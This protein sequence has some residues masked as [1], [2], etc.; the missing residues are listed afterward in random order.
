MARWQSC[1]ILD[2]GIEAHRLWQFDA[3]GG[4]FALKREHA[5]AAGQPLPPSLAAKSWR[6]LF[7][8]RLNIAWLPPENVFL[9]V[10]EL[11]SSNFEETLAMVELQLE[12]L[13]P[14]PVAQVVWTIHVLPEKAE[15]ASRHPQP[16]G[17]DAAATQMQTVVVVVAERKAVEEFLG[18]LEAQGYLADR[19][20]TPML[21]QLQATPADEDGAW[22]YPSVQNAQNAAL[23]AWWVGGVLRS[24]SFIVLATGSDR[25]ANLKEQLAHLVWAGEIEGWLTA[26]PKWHL[27]ADGA[28]AGEWETY[29]RDGLGEPVQVVKPLPPEELA[30]RTARRAAAANPAD[31]AL[32]PVEFSA[33]YH[34]QFVDRLWLRGLAAAGV[35]YVLAVAVYFC[36]TVFVGMQTRQVEQQV[37]AISNDY[38]NAMELKSKYQILTE[39]N[40]LKYAALDCWKVVADLLPQGITVERFSFAGGQTLTLS[41]T[42]TQD[43][44]NTLFDFNTAL[45]KAMLNG[46]PVFKTEGGEDVSPR[47]NP[48]GTVTWSLT[49]LLANA[50][51]S[52]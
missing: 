10:I 1:T 14:M 48:N 41:G 47:T 36:A 21:D 22:I 52:Q 18:K 43:Q 28:A 44:I 7:Q 34:H 33:R 38:T 35:L 26:T 24:L 3:K 23:V 27:V 2:V 45:K 17:E 25:A 12:K 19:L 49:L 4:G 31:A 11:P 42:T 9:R 39:R 20:E 32:L 8:P 6:S 37:A 29:L 16:T 46:K 30:A 50:E 51:E 40:E 5:G 15:A 13:S